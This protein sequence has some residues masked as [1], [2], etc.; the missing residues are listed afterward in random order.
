MKLLIS[1]VF[2]VALTCVI[3]VSGKIIQDSPTIDLRHAAG[4][5]QGKFWSFFS[6]ESN[7][8]NDTELPNEELT[9]SIIEPTMKD[10]FEEPGRNSSVQVTGHEICALR[11]HIANMEQMAAKMTSSYNEKY[12]QPL[13]CHFVFN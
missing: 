12:N 6:T 4:E 5:E 10:K 13:T 7:S 2:L 1:L 8:E 3:P 9:T 11:N